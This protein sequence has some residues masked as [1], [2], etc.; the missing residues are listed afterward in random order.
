MSHALGG[1][2]CPGKGALGFRWQ[3]VGQRTRS[4]P[5]P[6]QPELEQRGAGAAVRRGCGF[7]VG[8]PESLLLGNIPVPWLV[9][10]AFLRAPPAGLLQFWQ[11]ALEP[12]WDPC[13][14]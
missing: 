11:E 12:I 2:L 9:E 8:L 10:Q 1:T 14:S 6:V 13:G 7:P 4:S 3:D 5:S